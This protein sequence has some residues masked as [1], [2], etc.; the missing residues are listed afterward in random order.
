MVLKEMKT[1]GIIGV[2]LSFVITIIFEYVIRFVYRIYN[3]RGFKGRE[4]VE[5]K[6]GLVL[7]KISIGIK[8][9][10]VFCIGLLMITNILNYFL[11]M[12]MFRI[13]F[14]VFDRHVCY[15]LGNE[16]LD[17]YFL[18]YKVWF[19]K[20]MFIYQGK[21]YNILEMRELEYEGM[22]EKKKFLEIHLDCMSGVDGILLRKEFWTA[23][24]W[25]N[26]L[27]DGEWIEKNVAKRILDY[28]S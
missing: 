22:Y 17:S 25:S 20:D 5:R 12:I 15:G 16:Y 21:E 27:R 26:E 28:I 14:E 10:M 11:L 23:T 1:Y 3:T 13:L 9:I 6:K 2:L 4:K 19:V 8:I 18:R 7:A 24:K